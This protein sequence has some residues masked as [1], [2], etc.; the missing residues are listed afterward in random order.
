MAIAE[1][2]CVRVLDVCFK[3][4]VS[5]VGSMLFTVFRVECNIA[6]VSVALFTVGTFAV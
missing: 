6:T 3:G 2:L 1:C 4:Q 5:S